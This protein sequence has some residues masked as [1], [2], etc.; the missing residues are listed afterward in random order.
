MEAIVLAA[1]YSSRANA[2]KMT[3]QLGQMTVLEQTI[4]KFEG[5]CS[6][7]I[8]VAGFKMEL[9]QEEMAKVCNKNA[10]SFQ[11]KVVYNENF[12]QGMFTSIQRGCKEINAPAFFITPGDCPLVKKETV[13]LIS[14][15]KGNVVIPSFNYKG[16]HPIKL[17]SEV[18]QKILDTNPESSLREV[19]GGFEK[20]YVNVDDPGVIMDVDTLDDYQK[21]IDYYHFR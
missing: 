8:V 12:N 10:Y 3:L 19:L 5:L 18:K 2:F 17:S 11:V 6:R 4:S 7:V 20:E 14:K 15:Y 9:I 13:Q 21:A 16:G 1:G